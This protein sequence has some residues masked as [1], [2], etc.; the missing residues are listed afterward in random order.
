MLQKILLFV[1]LATFAAY[2]SSQCTGD[3]NP[4]CA[5]WVSNGFCTN[6][7]Y[8]DDIKRQNCGH[9]CGLCGPSSTI[10][11]PCVDA[12]ASCASWA[13]NGFCT[14]PSYSQSQKKQ[15]C[16]R[17]CNLCSPAPSTGNC[18][19][20]VNPQ[21]GTS[22]CGSMAHLCNNSAYYSLMTQECPKTC[23]RC[24]AS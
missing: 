6:T 16:A 4:N 17:T 13:Q 19:D 18:V 12:S 2:V 21:T 22:S 10:A 8:T 24:P 20:K 3:D 5:T 14:N 7:F 15:F 23:N 1:F 11:S 9:A